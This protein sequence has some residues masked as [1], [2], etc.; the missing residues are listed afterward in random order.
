MELDVVKNKEWKWQK[1]GKRNKKNN[2]LVKGWSIK[3]R[4]ISLEWIV[5]K[6]KFGNND[7]QGEI[8][9]QRRR[10]KLSSMYV[11]QTSEEV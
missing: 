2:D 5:V 6:E 1:D 9:E 4:K 7:D 10:L 3:N 11:W 8:K